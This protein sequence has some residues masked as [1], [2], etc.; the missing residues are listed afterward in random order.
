MEFKGRYIQRFKGLEYPL[1]CPSFYKLC[2]FYGCAWGKCRECYLRGTYFRRYGGKVP[3]PTIYK[4][5][6]WEKLK[7]ELIKFT[8][9]VETPQLL[10]IGE[11]ADS[12]SFESENFFHYSFSDLIIPFMEY[13]H[14]HKVLFLSKLTN[15]QGILKYQ[16]QK[17]TVLSWTINLPEVANLLGEPPNIPFRIFAGQKCKGLG[18]EVRIRIDPIIP[19]FN[20]T[21]LVM[22]LLD[23]FTPSRIT[24]GSLRINN[25]ILPQT[26]PEFWE[27]WLPKMVDLPKG[28]KRFPFELDVQC[29]SEIIDILKDCGYQGDI[30]VCKESVEVWDGLGLSWK[31]C[32]CNCQL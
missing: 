27:T 10:N 26:N 8:N 29:F 19:K 1:I 11:L 17:Q 14:K 13:R 28:K 22:A 6:T 20:Y 30:A 23:K 12:L 16:N 24:L 31:N 4:G 32:K 5:L 7:T 15:I 3:P 18:Y 25:P 2:A 21:S 9:I